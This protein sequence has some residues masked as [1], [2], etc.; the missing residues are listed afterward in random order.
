MNDASVFFVS[1]DNSPI[2]IIFIMLYDLLSHSSSFREYMNMCLHLIT[3]EFVDDYTGYSVS[4]CSAADGKILLSSNKQVICEATLLRQVYDKLFAA[5]KSGLSTVELAMQ[6]GLAHLEA[7]A[8]MKSICRKGL[9]VSALHD[10][11]KSEIRRCALLRG[12]QT[13]NKVG[14]F[15]LPTNSLNRNL[16]CVMQKSSDFV[17]QQNQPILSA[18]IEHVLS[19]TILSADFL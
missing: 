11:G 7:R 13:N 18:K 5:G 17:S 3:L 16:S 15:H 19:S 4:V 9:A 6:L 1:L 2:F 8:L 10:K 12:C 14:R